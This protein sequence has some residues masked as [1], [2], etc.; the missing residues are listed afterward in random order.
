VRIGQKSAQVTIYRRAEGWK[1]IVLH[2]SADAL[3][4]RSVGLVLPVAQIYEGVG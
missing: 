4:L 1:R 2:S 3:E